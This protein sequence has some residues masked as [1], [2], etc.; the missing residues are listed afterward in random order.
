MTKWMM[1]SLLQTYFSPTTCYNNVDLLTAFRCRQWQYATSHPLLL[2]L[3]GRALH[4]Y[5]VFSSALHGYTV[6]SSAAYDAC[7]CPG[8]TVL[9]LVL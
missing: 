3:V 6:L 2:V 5:T 4:G 9:D 7:T 8:L 1:D